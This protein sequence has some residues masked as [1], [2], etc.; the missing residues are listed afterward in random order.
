MWIKIILAAAG[1]LAS[2]GLY[3]LAWRHGHLVG[4][5]YAVRLAVKMEDLSDDEIALYTQDILD[6]VDKGE[7][8]NA[9]RAEWRAQYDAHYTKD[10]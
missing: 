5:E 8:R 3:M 9:A 10:A 7:I 6:R 2:V 4:V 1:V